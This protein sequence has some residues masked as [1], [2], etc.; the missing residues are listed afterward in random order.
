MDLSEFLEDAQDTLSK[1][2]DVSKVDKGLSEDT[3][4]K[5]DS[6]EVP[7]NRG[8]FVYDLVGVVVHTGLTISSGHYYSVV[9]D[10]DGGKWFRFD[11]E[12]VEPLGDEWPNC[13]FGGKKQGG[14]RWDDATKRWAWMK[15]PELGYGYAAV[16]ERQENSLKS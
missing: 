4:S 16:Y 13:L 1:E 8:K 3:G 12:T 9:K 6:E 15:Q 7:A 11:D 5:L 10:R 2:A 14:R